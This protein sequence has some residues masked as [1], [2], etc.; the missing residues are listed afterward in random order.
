MFKVLFLPDYFQVNF[1]ITRF[2]K[3]DEFPLMVLIKAIVI[4]HMDIKQFSAKHCTHTLSLEVS[5]PHENR[6]MQ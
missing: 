4:P 3:D 5:Q 6:G 1:L 2:S